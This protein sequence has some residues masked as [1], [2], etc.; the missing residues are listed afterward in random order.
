MGKLN[1]VLNDFLKD[2]QEFED[3]VNLSVYGGEKVICAS[4]LEDVE[5]EKCRPLCRAARR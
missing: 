5:P 1:N 2:N 3:I 4:D